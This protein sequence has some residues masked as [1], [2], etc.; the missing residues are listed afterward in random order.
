M[1]VRHSVCVY[2]RCKSL[3]DWPA[4]FTK[5]RLMVMHCTLAKCSEGHV[6]HIKLQSHVYLEL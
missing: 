1:C 3:F 5:V 6:K 2:A 4:A